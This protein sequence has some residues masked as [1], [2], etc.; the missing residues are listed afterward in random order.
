[1]DSNQKLKKV[2]LELA[3]AILNLNLKKEKVAKLKKEV[4]RKY[5]LQKIPSN[6]D[7]LSYFKLYGKDDEKY[8][9]LREILRLKPV[10]TI[11]GVAVVSVMT[12]PAPCPHGK[13]LPC[14]GGVER[15]TPQSYIGLEPAAMRGR[16][17]NYNAFKQVT[18]RLRELKEIGHEIDK[19][20]IIVM[21]GTFPAREKEYKENFMLSIFNA[22]NSFDRNV[23]L[24]NDLEKAKKKNEKAKA[25]C[26]GITFETRPDYAK[27]EHIVEMLK[28]GGTKVEL[29]VQS[30]Y[31]DV[32]EFI[33][34]GHD[35]EETIK[36]TR[37][38][39]D[40]AFKV[41]YHVMPGL[42]KSDFKRDL[43][44]FKEIFENENFKPDYLK[45][46]PTLVVEGTKL[47]EMWERREYKPYTTDEVVEL[48]AKA[49]KHFSEWVRV[50]RIQ[51]DIPINHAIGLDK[52]N[53]RQLVKQRLK[54][55]GYGCR[56]IRCREVGHLKVPAD[57]INKAEFVV[58]KYKAS[59]GRE[60]FISYEIPDY[61]ALVGFLRLRSPHK[62]FI[63]ALEDSALIRELHVYGKAIAVGKRS[64]AF[65]HKGFGERLLREAEEIAKEKYDKISVISGVGVR[66]YYRRFGY[67]K[68]FEYMV[69][70]I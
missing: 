1:M 5:K 40:S 9:R 69:K 52:G 67:R 12:S 49:K 32:L 6:A 24:E 44:M 57:E 10:R 13:C 34:R 65:Q 46:Y 66:D 60:Y 17:H 35:V 41:G 70:K 26:I 47:Y 50:Q 55:L 42:P 15:N 19:V 20:E 28:F 45:I 11:S 43:R 56:C 4:C 48:I 2:C 8:G 23:K 37:L 7:I 16:Q 31:N 64:D 54:E 38:L 61:D 58:R 68:N 51:R 18:A 62:P 25:R 39:K 3:Y 21:G 33:Q 22:L 29:G 30:I 14:P 27:Q 59:K 53:I 63:K 36:A